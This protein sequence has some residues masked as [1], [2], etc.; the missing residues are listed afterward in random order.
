M[1][2]G[3]NA[4]QARAKSQQ[5]MIVFNE[6]VAIMQE[7]LSQ[8]TDGNFEAYVDDSTTMT[9]CTPTAIK[10]GT[11]NNPT[12]IPGS[13]LIIQGTTVVL[14]TSGTNLN[15]IIADINDAEING[16]TA[17]KDGNYLVLTIT[18]E[19][20]SSWSYTIGAG[21]ANA[22]LGLTEGT[23]LVADPASVSY[24][25]TWIGTLTDRGLQSQ[26]DQVLRYFTNLGYK[27]ER[28][29]NQQTGITFRWHVYW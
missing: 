24:Y 8:S 22:A 10:L 17:S 1:N 12:I 18:L 16:V 9:E 7:I 23:Y 2:I 3:L 27:I 19:P 15:S 28:I 25:N 13:T 14:G 6:T 29:S 5:D 4:A 21:T 20:S 26:M 11:V